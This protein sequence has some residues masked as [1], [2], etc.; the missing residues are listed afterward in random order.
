MRRR[1]ELLQLYGV[2]TSNEPA[3]WGLSLLISLN[4]AEIARVILKIYTYDSHL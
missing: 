1:L 3:G 4:Q 2:Q